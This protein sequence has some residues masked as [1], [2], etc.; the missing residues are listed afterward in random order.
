VS[1]YARSVS[2]GQSTARRTQDVFRQANE[3]LLRAVGDR[4]HEDRPIP[5]LCECLSAS[6]RG[7]VQL[8]I[9]QFRRLREQ[10]NRF[11]IVTGH[12][13]ANGE[14]AVERNGEVSIVE[15]SSEA[16]PRS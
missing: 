3:R 2:T 11:A 10:P 14:R 4:V 13:L 7:T 15:K 8:T 9:E 5:F 12:P 6:C 16:D 1:G